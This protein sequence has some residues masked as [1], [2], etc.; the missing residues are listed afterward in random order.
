MSER[1]FRAGRA[2]E[3]SAVGPGAPAGAGW[4]CLSARRWIGPAA[5]VGWECRRRGAELFPD[6]RSSAVGDAGL[7]ADGSSERKGWVT[8]GYRSI[9]CVN[10][11]GGHWRRGD[12][13]RKGG[14]AHHDIFF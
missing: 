6:L 3:C 9:S 11:P 10:E 8:I 12:R 13:E 4:E 2:G 5:G 14:L 1:C 7:G